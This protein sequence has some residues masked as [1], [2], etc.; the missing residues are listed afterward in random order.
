[1]TPKRDRFGFDRFDFM[2]L[3]LAVLTYPG[4]LHLDSRCALD[5]SVSLTKRSYFESTFPQKPTLALLSP[6][7]L[8]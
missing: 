8:L 4:A 2:S 1:M 7:A 3:E 5:M 6:C